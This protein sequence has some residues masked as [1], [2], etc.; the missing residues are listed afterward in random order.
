MTQRMRPEIE[1]LG[2]VHPRAALC[3][4]GVD[5]LPADDDER[6]SAARQH[7]RGAD[8]PFA[9]CAAGRG[10]PRRFTAAQHANAEA[11]VAGLRR[12]LATLSERGLVAL[13]ITV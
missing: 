5:D 6:R 10:H 2:G 7:L 9:C 12:Y 3:H 11:L 8:R 4:R 13:L 1:Q